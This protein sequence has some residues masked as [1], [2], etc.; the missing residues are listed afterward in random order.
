MSVRG[1]KIWVGQSVLFAATLS[2]SLLFMSAA[3]Q[4]P[5]FP[6]HANNTQAR[7]AKKNVRSKAPQWTRAQVA[8]LLKK[9]SKRDFLQR[10]EHISRAFRNTPY[11][12]S[13]LGE[14]PGH[15]P[16]P[17]PRL[18]FDQFD[19][20]TFVE[21]MLALSLSRDIDDSQ[22]ILDRLRYL[23][24]SVSFATRKHFPA[25][26]WIP[27]NIAAG[28]FV[29]VTRQ[30]AGDKTQWADKTLTAKDWSRRDA[31]I[32]PELA[33]E[34]IPLGEHR[35]PI[36]PFVEIPHLLDKIPNAVV[37]NFV[38]A[39]FHNIPVRVSH[40]GFLFRRHGKLILRHAIAKSAMRVVD[41]DFAAY[42]ERA[43]RYKSWPVSGINL[44]MP[45]Q[46]LAKKE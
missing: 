24:G 28:F 26:Q 14:G 44:L 5:V 35:V 15:S 19:C 34:H 16:D 11:A 42:I 22:H 23:N 40:Q 46:M 12:F 39:D 7:L 18:R 20:T 21:T 2:S 13:P 33:V 4:K 37:V 1:P 43:K 8:V 32:L 17:D 6:V 41:E 9:N 3:G 31:K 30:V 29:D 10:L 45:Q 27:D 25:A 36:V 38:R